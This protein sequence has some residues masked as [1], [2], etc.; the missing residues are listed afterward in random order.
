MKTMATIFTLTGLL[1]SFGIYKI[2]KGMMNDIAQRDDCRSRSGVYFQ[3]PNPATGGYGAYK[4]V[5][6]DSDNYKQMTTNGVKA[7]N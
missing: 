6:I 2:Y 1:F 3:Y 7:Y 5:C 4:T